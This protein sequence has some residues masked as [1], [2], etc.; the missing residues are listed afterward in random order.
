VARVP[1]ASDGKL[2]GS[3]VTR[4][5]FGAERT[6]SESPELAAARK[7]VGGPAGAARQPSA[8]PTIAARR[9]RCDRGVHEDIGEGPVAAKKLEQEVLGKRK[10]L[11]MPRRNAS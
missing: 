11:R 3:F 4:G 2:A 1:A 5:P 8:H 7:R 6:L 9:G 10:V